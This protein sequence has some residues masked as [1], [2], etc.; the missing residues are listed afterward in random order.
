MTDSEKRVRIIER[1]ILRL[2]KLTHEDMARENR[3]K[4]KSL[5]ER[6]RDR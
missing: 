5:V 4:K 6:F 1:R 2:E 3:F